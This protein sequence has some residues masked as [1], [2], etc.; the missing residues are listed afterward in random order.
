MDRARWRKVFRDLLGNKTRTALVVLSIAV[1][2][3]AIG[4]IAGTS[5]IISRDMTNSFD[6]V[7]ASDAVIYT[8]GFDD[9]FADAMRHVPGVRDAQGAL[10]T[11]VRIHLSPTDTRTLQLDSIPDQGTRRINKVTPLSGKWP[12]S[13]KEIVLERESLAW[14]GLKEG[15]RITVETNDNHLRDLRVVGTALFMNLPP[16]SFA[17][18]SYGFASL[19]TLESL[20]AER[21]YNALA[22]VVDRAQL[23]KPHIEDV[24]ALVRSRVEKSG[25]KV[26]YTYI[27]DPGRYPGASSIDAVMLLLGVLGVFSLLLSGF[28]VVNTV[29]ALLAQ[30]TR[31]I[32]VMKAIGARTT[33][34]VGMYVATLLGFGVLALLVGVPLGMLASYELSAY[35]AGIIDVEVTSFVPPPYVF[36]LEAAV[37]LAVPVLAGLWPTLAGTRVS[38][39]EA[40]NAEGIDHTVGLRSWIDRVVGT[41]RG[42]SR[43]LLIS[44][45]NTFRRKGRLALTMSTL[46]LGGAIFVAVLSVW[47]STAK[48]IEDA[49][50]YF[51][52]DVEVV[53]NRAYHNDE[54]IAAG[55][56]VPGVADAEMLAGDTVRR[57]RPGPDKVESN[58]V[59][60][61]ALPAQTTLIKPTLIA[62]RWLLPDDE[63]AVVVNSTFLH[64]E[65]DVQLGDEL[66]IKIN[67]KDSTWKVVGIVRGVMTGSMIYANQPYYMRVTNNLG[68]ST[69][70]WV[71]GTK[72]DPASEDQVAKALEAQLKASGINVQQTQTIDFTRQRVQGQFNIVV[73]LL[74]VMAALLGVVGGLGLMGT[75]SL[76]VLERTREIG[77]MRAIGASNGAVR[78]IFIVEGILIGVLSWLIGSVVALPASKLLSD[79]V[80]ISFIQ[81]PLSYVFSLSGVALWLVIVVA[82]ATLASILPAR[83]ASRL[84]VRDVLAYE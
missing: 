66:T 59:T 44:L 10:A 35:L 12:P 65:P 67:A 26:Y 8:D 75:M 34:I 30:Q 64:D 25:R 68:N 49:L 14:L 6:A 23:N 16:P 52:Y 31:Q 50:A 61:L 48:T 79:Q 46:T 13:I 4:M 77:V 62:G 57:V 80:G 28:L 42:L 56:L 27:P 83:A 40:L 76:N 19:D 73:A 45:R 36:G 41:V 74:L 71:V 54:V 5:Y 29:S 60:L 17:G 81:T 11:T 20:G 21:K 84:T 55:A 82:I 2:I 72:H 63:N 47:Q 3:L 18:A 58:N 43:P 33:Q 39:R 70:L 53:L 7:N 9:A 24:A 37:G 78:Q 1:G 69:T 38:V 15:D 22:I 51:N 32:G